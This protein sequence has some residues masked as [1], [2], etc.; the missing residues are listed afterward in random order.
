MTTPGF[1]QLIALNMPVDHRINELRQVATDLR[2]ERTFAG[3]KR[4]GPN[5]FRLAIGT[6]LVGLGS[7]IAGPRAGLQVR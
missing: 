7:A 6:A 3:P 2:N 5:R 1:T 4:P